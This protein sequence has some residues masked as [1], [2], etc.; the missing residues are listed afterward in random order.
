MAERVAGDVR[1][2]TASNRE[3]RSQHKYMTRQL[4]NTTSE[5]SPGRNT[6]S[7]DEDTVSSLCTR[8]SLYPRTT[9]N[10]QQ[11][12]TRHAT[13]LCPSI[14][15]SKLHSSAITPSSFAEGPA[16]MKSTDRN[17]P[18]STRIGSNRVNRQANLTP[19][20]S[21][22][23]TVGRHTGRAKDKDSSRTVQEVKEED[24]QT[25]PE[26]L[27]RVGKWN[28]KG[29][30][31]C[32]SGES[33][34]ERVCNGRTVGEEICNGDVTGWVGRCLGDV[35]RGRGMGGGGDEVSVVDSS[36]V[37]EEE[38]TR[39]SHKEETR[40]KGIEVSG[41][42]RIQ[43]RGLDL[44]KAI[45]ERDRSVGIL[46][47][48]ECTPSPG[49]SL[50]RKGV[51]RRGGRGENGALTGGEGELEA[52]HEELEYVKA[53]LHTAQEELRKK[54]EERT[55]ADQDGFSL[56]LL[57]R[58]SCA[59]QGQKLNAAH[60]KIAEQEALIKNLTLMVQTQQVQL[61]SIKGDTFEQKREHKD[62]KEQ[63]D[64]RAVKKKEVLAEIIDQIVEPWE[65][66]AATPS[67][68]LHLVSSEWE[69]LNLRTCRKVSPPSVSPTDMCR[70][71]PPNR[72][73]CS[74]RTD[75][76]TLTPSPSTPLDCVT[77]NR[78][79]QRRR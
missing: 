23:A 54:E 40:P 66:N 21:P 38:D 63:K 13:A 32:S 47:P 3:T 59:E 64:K 41:E 5:T 39:R 72:R 46:P 35:R 9:A 10:I 34:R 15:S 8:H 28:D 48:A 75:I 37:T 11:P 17:V 26:G 67:S 1:Q 76:P 45:L 30:G 19:K 20:K 71:H 62:K 69:R 25:L 73:N 7:H 12:S 49:A 22:A 50:R 4:N 61:E 53:K 18:K 31:D 24:G 74:H 43:C 51:G 42:R 14:D 68:L 16:A 58:R 2:V 52:A 79:T 36:E 44:S 70:T 29:D 55:K 6:D 56:E 57:L 77:T 78:T 65:G 27:C 33:V 60:T